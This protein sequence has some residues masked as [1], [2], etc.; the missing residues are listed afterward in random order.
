MRAEGITMGMIEKFRDLGDA[1]DVARAFALWFLDTYGEFPGGEIT[2]D[3]GEI[4]VD[5]LGGRVV[6]LVMTER[7][8]L[9]MDSERKGD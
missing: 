5:T 4:E 6:V 7:D 2:G 1:Q 9:M 3:G 8:R